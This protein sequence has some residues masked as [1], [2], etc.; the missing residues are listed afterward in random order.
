[1]GLS[2]KRWKASDDDI[3]RAY[4]RKVLKHHPDKKAA[5]SGNSNDDNFFK[6]IQKAW[7]ILSDEKKRRQ[8]DA[9]DPT[10]DESI[11]K[12]TL[13][14]KEDFL[15]IYGECFKSNA[16]FSVIHPVPEIGTM[17][18][19]K[20]EVEEFYQFWYKFQSWRSF[21][22]EDEDDVDSASCREEKRWLERK[23]KAARAKR[24]KED[25]QRITRLVDQAYKQ[26]P[27]LLKFKADE[28]AAK[29]EK[30]LAKERAIQEELDKVRLQAEAEEAE[31]ARLAAEE[32][33]K[34]C[35][36]FNIVA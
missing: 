20:E 12:S 5:T 11:P 3:K 7:E 18:S 36:K 25:N 35:A 32:K 13:K 22:A 21:E 28:K 23:N 8:W 2:N 9:V 1:M 33:S 14:P 15:T 17:D 16:R 4:R 34:V 31:K 29:E 6:C 27:R 26:D 19:S 10:F 30:R 24:K